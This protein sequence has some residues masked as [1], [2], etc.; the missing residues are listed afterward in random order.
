M[1]KII[2]IV[3]DG[4]GDEPVAEL[5]N[6]TPL[7]AALT[8]NM[9]RLAQKGRTGMVQIFSPGIAPESDIAVISLLGYNPNKCYTGRGPLE[10]FSEGIELS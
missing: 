5:G 1:K 4:I 10:A 7:E 3:L 8:P 2:Y 9:D 6:K